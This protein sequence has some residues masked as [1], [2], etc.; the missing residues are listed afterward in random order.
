[1]DESPIPKETESVF[2][3]LCARTEEDRN[4]VTVVLEEF[5]FLTE[6]GW[7]HSRCERE[8]V[9]Y[10]A[11]ADRAKENGKLGG[12]PPKTKVVISDNQEETQKKA[13]QEPITNNHKPL[14][15]NQE[16]VEKNS[17]AKALPCPQDVDPQIWSDFLVVRKAKRAP[18]TETA[19]KQLRNEAEK[20]GV[21]FSYAIQECVARG[22]QSFKASWFTDKKGKSLAEQEES[23]RRFREWLGDDGAIEGE[24]VK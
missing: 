17:R 9:A 22:W 10:R 4:A 16:P 20:A 24:V 13:N 2:R 3:R 23:D 6:K 21:T 12:R 5:F 8:I 18:I 1:M 19:I 7:E 15:N 11:K 14:T